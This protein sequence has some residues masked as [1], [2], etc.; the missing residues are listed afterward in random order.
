MSTARQ[1]SLRQRQ[2][3]PHSKNNVVGAELCNM[4]RSLLRIW[5]ADPS[6]GLT[7]LSSVSTELPE[8]LAEGIRVHTHIC[9]YLLEPTGIRKTRL[10]HL[11]RT[12]TR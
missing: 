8:V 7:Y 5:Q 6:S 4:N 3:I 12:D 1:T 2:I 9:L 11:C 10:T